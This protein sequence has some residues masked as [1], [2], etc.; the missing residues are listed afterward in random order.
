[1]RVIGDVEMDYAEFI[2]DKCC[3]PY[4]EIEWL[5]ANLKEEAYNEVK[6]VLKEIK[7]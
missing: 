2:M 1:M 5:V 6:E 7:K 4:D 3:E